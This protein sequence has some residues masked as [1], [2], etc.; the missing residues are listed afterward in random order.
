LF[1]ICQGL[2]LGDRCYL[3]KYAAIFMVT[4]TWRAGVGN[5]QIL[6]EGVLLIIP[7]LTILAGIQLYPQL[8]GDLLLLYTLLHVIHD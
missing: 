2:K 3:R 5:V 4:Q 1:T 8:G 7:Y 6:D